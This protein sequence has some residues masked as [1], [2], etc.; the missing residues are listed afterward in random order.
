[1]SL[2][3]HSD[4]V[5]AAVLYLLLAVFMIGPAIAK[6][7]DFTF[8]EVDLRPNSD[9]YQ[10]I[11]ADGDIVPGTADKFQ[12]FVNS[13]PQL[14]PDATV[15]LNSPGGS[16]AEG[17]QLG[18]LIRSLRFRTAV[19]VIGTEPLKPKAGQCLSACIFPY[20]GGEYRYLSDDSAIGIHRFR[21][22]QDL[23]GEATAEITQQL[24]GLIVEYIKQSRADPSLYAIMAQTP[25]DDI[26]LLSVE[27]LVRLRVVTGD[28]YSEEWSFEI[29]GDTPYLKAHQISWRGQSKLIFVCPPSTTKRVPLLMTLSELPDRETI[30]REAKSIILIIDGRSIPVSSENVAETPEL[31]D[32]TYVRWTTVLTPQLIES[33]KFADKIGSGISPGPPEMFAGVAGINIGSGREKLSQFLEDCQ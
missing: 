25:P 6:E 10:W 9:L 3:K 12:S 20:L 17:M 15:M 23:G 14:I 30:I 1:V 21:F 28:T 2:P 13:H 33:L 7:M 26:H 5:F 11:F 16:P 22:Q 27:D 4:A 24:S 18:K 32:D 8:Q 19:G 31:S 29:N